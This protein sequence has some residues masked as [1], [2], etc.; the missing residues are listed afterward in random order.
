MYGKSDGSRLVF[1]FNSGSQESPN[2][3]PAVP[4][5]SSI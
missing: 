3:K 2:W 5:I 1:E 4:F